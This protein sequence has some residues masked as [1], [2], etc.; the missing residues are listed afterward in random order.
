MRQNLLG[1]GRFNSRRFF[2]GG[3]FNSRR[4]FGGGRFNDRSFFSGGRSSFLTTSRQSQSEQ[5][6]DEEGLFHF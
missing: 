4:F 3:R 1:S 5:G 6:G 2:G